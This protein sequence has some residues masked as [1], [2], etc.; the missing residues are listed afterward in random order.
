MAQDDRESAL[1]DAVL[2]YS[3]ALP[4]RFDVEAALY[5]L[6]L[7]AGRIFDGAACGVMVV[8]T[9]GVLRAVAGSDSSVDRLEFLQLEL[10]EGPCLTAYRTAEPVWCHDLAGDA[11]WPRFGPAAAR[12]GMAGVLSV[13]MAIDGHCI[14]AYNVFQDAPAEFA[15]EVV[16][17]ARILASLA[18]GYVVA[19]RTV[20]ERETLAAQLQEA[21]DGRV[22]IEQA[23][24]RLSAE[25]DVDPNAAFH[26]LRGYA[27]SRQL[28]L[29]EVAGRVMAGELGGDDL[30]AAV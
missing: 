25:L 26:V 18:T 4:T 20:K 5:S 9:S 11:R 21:L 1:L 10:G 24:G 6:A 17:A 14:G 12:S 2:E 23:K 27:R 13:P 8:D 16:V 22:V 7:V 28:R 29:R 19:A 3:L 30:T 15:P